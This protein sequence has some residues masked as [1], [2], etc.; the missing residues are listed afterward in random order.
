MTTYKSTYKA[1]DGTVSI[2]LAEERLLLT[3]CEWAGVNLH[4]YN[5]FT[6]NMVIGALSVGAG[7]ASVTETWNTGKLNRG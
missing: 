3:W 1:T 2:T 5:M 6:V 4:L 7:Y